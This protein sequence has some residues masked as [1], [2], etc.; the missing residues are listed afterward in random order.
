M[1]LDREKTEPVIRRIVD[2][3]HEIAKK[4]KEPYM[5]VNEDERPD[6]YKIKEL[7][8]K[9]DWPKDTL[10]LEVVYES[11][12]RLHTPWGRLELLENNYYRGSGLDIVYELGKRLGLKYKGWSKCPGANVPE[13]SRLVKLVKNESDKVQAIEIKPENIK[14]VPGDLILSWYDC[15]HGY[16]EVTQIDGISIETL[17]NTS[18]ITASS[19][20]TSQSVAATSSSLKL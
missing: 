9:T 20:V 5:A 1:G 3:T 13:P 16:F 14:I 11:P 18:P 6:K 17:I 4:Y 19:L 2:I 10:E 8:H 7:G 12:F 15:D